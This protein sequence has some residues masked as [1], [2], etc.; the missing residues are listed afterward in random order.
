MSVPP[1]VMKAFSPLSR[2]PLPRWLARVVNALVSEPAFGSVPA[3]PQIFRPATMSG[4]YF[5]ANSG[6]AEAPECQSGGD[7]HHDADGKRLIGAR[8]LLERD[9]H[10]EHA[11][12]HAAQV[13]AERNRGDAELAGFLEQLGRENAVAIERLGHRRDFALRE[14]GHRR[15]QFALIFSEIEIHSGVSLDHHLSRGSRG[16]FCAGRENSLRLPRPA[17]LVLE[18]TRRKFD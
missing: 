16:G 5:L 10:V 12:P 13:F 17:F 3:M 14:I 4:S 11:K 8:Q 15:L 18:D 7:A 2:Q 9:H 6:V 1:L